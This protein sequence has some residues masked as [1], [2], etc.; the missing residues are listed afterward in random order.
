MKRYLLT[1]LTVA[2]LGVAAPAAWAGQVFP[3]EK[4]P[5]LNVPKMKAPPQIDGVIDPAEWRESVK[6]MGVVSTH[7][8]AYKDRPV[9]FHVAWDDQHLYIAA[10]SDIL[11]GHR[12]WR[13]RRD[14]FTTGVVYDDSYEFGIF[15]HDRN[16]LPQEAS[17]FQKIIINSLGAGEYVKIYPSIARTCTTGNPTRRSPTASTKRA[18][19]SGGRWRWP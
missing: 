18:A 4:I 2:A 6:V 16:K 5:S 19:N 9:S 12:M 10:V 3:A 1:L 15:L 7:S 14:R 8:L 11:P 13:G 17:S